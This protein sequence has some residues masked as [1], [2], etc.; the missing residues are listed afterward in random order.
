M[1]LL[2]TQLGRFRIIAFLEGLSF[3]II[4]FVTMPLKYQFDM[5]KPNLV[6]GMVHGVLFMVYLY[7]A[8]RLK[9]SENWDNKL[10]LKT[11]AASIIPF[12]TFY[13]DHKVFRHL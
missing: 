4:L 12:G 3:I 7:A 1:K 8:F 5:P 9:I 11:L 10:T 6:V 2:R 13:M